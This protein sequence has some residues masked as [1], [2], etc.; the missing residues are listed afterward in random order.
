MVAGLAV[1]FGANALAVPAVPTIYDPVTGFTWGL[2]FSVSTLLGTTWSSKQTEILDAGYTPA[3]IT[4]VITMYQNLYGATSANFTNFL[5]DF[6][7][8]LPS[9]NGVAYTTTPDGLSQYRYVG[10]VL[11]TFLC[12]D[13]SVSGTQNCIID[14]NIASAGF[15]YYTVA[16]PTPEPSMVGLF[17]GMMLSMAWIAHR[18]LR[19]E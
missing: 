14:T 10:K 2:P 7:F 18:K 17:G 12:L 1:G 4:D 16:T 15:M 19:R 6:G 8:P 9:L 5:T 13:F 3:S 11:D